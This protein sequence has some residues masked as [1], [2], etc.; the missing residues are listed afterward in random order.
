MLKIGQ[1]ESTPLGP[2][3][4]ALSEYG[5]AAVQIQADEAGF[6]RALAR[7]PAGPV[8]FDAEATA[9]VV[10]QLDDYLHG[11]RRDF[12]LSIDWSDLN[13]FQ[14][15][16]LRATLA[17]PYGEVRTYGQ[18]AQQ[19]GHSLGAARAVGR[20]MATNPMPIIIPCHRVLGADGSLHGY[21]APG[22]ITTKAWLLRLEGYH[23]PAQQRFPW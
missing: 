21:G 5:L 4:L 13:A 8:V 15:A 9:G 23:L 10:Q 12:D 18:I 19:L 7:H 11:R 3:W 16:A 20:A 1:V 6:R 17:I 2:I 22:G 14:E